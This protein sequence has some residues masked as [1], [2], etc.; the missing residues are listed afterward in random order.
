MRI[1][2]IYIGREPQQKREKKKKRFVQFS[3]VK[4]LGYMN[5]FL[6]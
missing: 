5:V 1:L 2:M 4:W 6:M 3:L